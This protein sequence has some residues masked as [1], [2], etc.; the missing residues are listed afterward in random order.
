[1]TRTEYW[2]M[3]PEDI[4]SSYL[5][6]AEI[7][8]ERTAST[9]QKPSKRRIFQHEMYVKFI[10]HMASIL[11][12]EGGSNFSKAD[13][14]KRAYDYSSVVVLLRAALETFLT[15][16]YVYCDSIEPD[17]LEFR[18]YNWLT[19]GLGF[20]Q[21]LDVSF[22]K[23]LI[24]RQT[25]ERTEIDEAISKMEQ[26]DAFGR[27][28]TKQKRIVVEKLEWIRPGWTDILVRAGFAEYWARLFYAQ[29]SM[30][31]HTSSQSIMQFRDA[32]TRNEGALLSS[33][34]ANFVYMAAAKF[35]EYYIAHFNLEGS[36][37]NEQLEM[38]EAWT[39][40]ASHLNK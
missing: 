18:Y 24:Q 8:I 16:Y 29:Y 34:F 25:R 11:T 10:Y 3:K 38:L 13:V 30:Y 37:K 36:L 39:W 15:Y 27:L 17:E 1:M 9:K 21:Q 19:D 40:M 5:E 4:Y 28:T 32:T 2:K 35:T 20:R 26:T 23:E 6:M 7:L 31:A 33:T 14:R 22:S 12:L